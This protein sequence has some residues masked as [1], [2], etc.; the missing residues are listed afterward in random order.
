[1]WSRLRRERAAVAGRQR[2][3][4]LRR[5][6]PPKGGAAALDVLL[7]AEQRIDAML[8]GHEAESARILEEARAL[9]ETIERGWDA[10]LQTAIGELRQQIERERAASL[11]DIERAAE[12]EA[13]RYRELPR[14]EVR[15]LARWLAARVARPPD[16]S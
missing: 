6:S 2:E 1:M 12:A 7:E 5:G 9:A 16:A 11:G 3:R 8:A 14:E 15:E 13:T 10:N 4:R